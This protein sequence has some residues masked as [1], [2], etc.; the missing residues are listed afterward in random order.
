MT[1]PRL[2]RTSPIAHYA[3]G[4]AL[5]AL[6]EDAAKC[7]NATIRLGVVLCVMC[8]CMNYTRRFYDEV[9]KD[10]ATASPLVFP[11]TVYN[12]TASH[13]AA[14][15]GASS[16]NYTLI[17][18][19]ATFI[20]GIALAADWLLS[21]RVDGC[22]VLGAEEMDWL[23]ADALRLFD[24]EAVLS[25]GA[26]AL[27]LK[28]GPATDSAVR[29][30]AITQP[31]LFFDGNSRARAAQRARAELSEVTPRD[32][33][34]DGLSGTLRADHDEQAAWR[35][36][37][38]PRLSPKAVLGEALMAGAAWQ[39]LAA[40]DALRQKCY[41]AATVSVVGCNQ[42]AIA[43]QFVRTPGKS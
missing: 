14:L 42:Q 28:A 36:W 34:C 30:Q 23:A 27:Y 12:S 32:L 11:E 4:A 35:D 15:L 10:P 18:D 31:H 26:G 40:V 2:R 1:H 3:V 22:L 37:P 38:G 41:D 43:A 17:G 19:P 21:G 24:R 7:G 13:L 5:E 29:L 20:Q 16:V 25:D 9:L 39:C 6:G 8:G 33:L